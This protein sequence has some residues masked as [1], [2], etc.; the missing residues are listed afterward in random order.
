MPI[1][2]TIIALCTPRLVIFILWLFST[3]FNGVFQT[4]G[5]PLLGFLFLPFSL[6]WYSAVTNWF[7]G[8]WNALA[9]IGM[10]IAVCLDLGIGRNATKKRK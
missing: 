4:V 9:M 8:Q 3:W 1:L 7:G 2:L 10:V 6:L 5:W